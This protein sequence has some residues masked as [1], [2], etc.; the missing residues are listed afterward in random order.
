MFIF[1]EIFLACVSED[2]SVIQ[3]GRTFLHNGIRHKCIVD[4]DS[5]K[6]E[7]SLFLLLLLF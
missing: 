1:Y 3:I 6:Y 4:G 7:Q 2:K 5:V